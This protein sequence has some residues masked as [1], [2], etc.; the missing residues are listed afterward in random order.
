[1]ILKTYQQ[2]ALEQLDRWL[3]VLR[4]DRT[5]AKKAQ[6]AL[7]DAGLQDSL[8]GLANYPKTA[9]QTLKD[10]G[11]LPTIIQD[12]EAETPDYISRTADCGEPIP[13]V[14]MRV[15][16]GGGKTLLGV[17]A[18]ERL[19][20][21]KGF[22][23]WV[24]P[25]R[26]IYE[27]TIKAFRTR[28]HPYRQMLERISGGK[29]KL[30]EKT[31]RFT[32]Q[33]V[34]NHLCVMM[35]MLPSANRQKGKEFLKIF[36][37][38]GGYTSFFPEQDDLTASNKFLEKFTDLEKIEGSN[39]AK[40]SLINVLKL[41]RPCVIL[42]EAHKAYGATDK[43]NKDFVKSV[44]RL[45]PRYVL[46]LSATP[47][48]GISNILVN[49]GG[50][51]LKDEEM[52][53]LPIEIHNF[54]NSD[55]K[56]TL[57]ETQE[58]L[59]RLE[60]DAKKVKRRNNRYIRPIALV[61]VQRTGKEQ[62]ETRYIHAE[63][64]REYLIQ[65]LSVAEQHI[66]VQ[67]SEQKELAQE[68]LLSEMSSVRWIITKDALK[69]GWD[70]SF[71]YI[72]ALLDNTK[73]KTAI[74]QMVGRVMRQPHAKLIDEPDSLNHCYI[75]CYNEDVTEAVEWVKSGLEKE[76][77]TGLGDS[78]IGGS[79]GPPPE[80]KKIQRRKP[81]KKLEIFLP[82][83]LHIDKTKWRLID[84]DRD[85][86]GSLS[87]DKIKPGQAVNLEEGDATVE[88][89]AIV[90]IL[91]GEVEQDVISEQILKGDELTI[92]YFVRRLI[93]LI[94][95]PWQAARIAEMFIRSHKTDKTVL[96]QNRIYLS[97]ILLRR[98]KE[99]ID[100][101][102]EDI[103]RAKIKKNEIKFHLE[104]DLDLNY[105]FQKT[106]EIQVG[107]NEKPLSK[108]GTPVQHS[109]FDTVFE[110]EFNKLEKNFAFCLDASN[111]I[112]WWHKIAAK[113]QYFIQGWRRNRVY[114]DFVVCRQDEEKYLVL[115][116]KGMHL[117]G[118]EDTDYK[119]K[120][121]EILEDTYKGALERGEMRN[122]GEVGETPA[123]YKILFE[124]SWKEEL[125]EALN[126]R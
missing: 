63:D 18:L 90:D 113:Q 48:V 66:R 93:D 21:E 34:E 98:I 76:G 3:E 115:E 111:S 12:G 6:K 97:E 59:K 105:E 121:F 61:R 56:R 39:C 11:V 1:M 126:A 32:R 47:K 49:V 102:A 17:A 85:I 116:T 28:E 10:Q 89:G 36:R 68:D 112:F 25:S 73:A 78:V 9:W 71:A 119:E 81:Y 33:D 19:S 125:Q 86:L 95:N 77:L 60:L 23:L 120:L 38:S 79:D 84:Y 16:T 101:M 117:K 69:E 15:P 58:K 104:A 70:C 123:T 124:N 55:W 13:H 74:T 51:E 29:V 106:F 2:K 4:E 7:A 50:Q 109:L 80:P 67:S 108:H 54:N 92:D 42:D 114:P 53:K 64:V 122:L 43:G 31:N 30:L 22:V 118:N 41:I 8:D 44:N 72:L 57:A 103:F 52:I 45:N 107:E 24:V 35:L 87:W 75:Y 91:A 20:P 37:D 110:S 82:Q 94:P 46:E 62:R 88:R 99:H 27:Q 100:G 14:C 40:Q 26:A 83:V 5:K 96:V 65:N